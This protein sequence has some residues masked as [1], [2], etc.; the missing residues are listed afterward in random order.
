MEDQWVIKG[1]AAQS[2]ARLWAA[3]RTMRELAREYGIP[4]STIESAVRE[5]LA[6]P[7]TQKESP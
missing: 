4:I 6:L 2:L 3:G 1:E 7:H 5:A